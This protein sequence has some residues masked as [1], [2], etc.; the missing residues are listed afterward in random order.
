M[1]L[2]I[3]ELR[4]KLETRNK[5]EKEQDKEEAIEKKGKEKNPICAAYIRGDCQFGWKGRQCQ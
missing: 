5:E 4:A 2:E 3:R 1:E